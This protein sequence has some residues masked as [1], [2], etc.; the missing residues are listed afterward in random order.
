[1]KNTTDLKE[2]RAEIN[3]IDSQLLDLLM[4]RREISKNV[5]QAKDLNDLPI[6]DEKREKEILEQLIFTGKEKGLSEEYIKKIFYEIIEDSVHLQ[7]TFVQRRLNKKDKDSNRI[8]VAIQGIEGAY[9]YLAAK[10]FFHD[11]DEEIEIVSEER[12]EEVARRVEKGEADYA[13]LPVENTTSGGI[14]E[15]YDVLLHTTLSIIGEEKFKVNHCLCAVEDVPLK[16]VKLIFAHHQAAAQCS[17]FISSLEDAKVEYFA[18]T[19]MSV[20]KIKE[21]NNK[22]YG[23][24]ASREAAELF[25][26]KILKTDIANQSENYTRFLV[27]A[28]KPISVDPRVSSKTSIV[29]ATSHTVGSLVEGLMVFR[30]YNINLTK[31]ES[32]PIIGNPWEQMFYVDFEGCV[33]SEK[34][35]KALDEIIPFTRFM[36]VLGSYPTKELP[37]VK[38]VKES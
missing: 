30:K 27:C 19:A 3:S 10:Q 9:S 36:K 8:K 11:Y 24:I 12:F 38:V 25:G 15:V 17:K 20:Q 32:R 18:D 6:R 16:E 31:L 13:M 34:V 22:N 21:E 29:F 26:V 37:K 5:I 2:L 14:N 1:M 7:Q 4:Q 23:A 33:E 28:R 35:R